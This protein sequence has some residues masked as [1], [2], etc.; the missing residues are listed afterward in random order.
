MKTTR[1]FNH[2]VEVIVKA[3]QNASTVAN[4][5]LRHVDH[6]DY[7]RQAHDTIDECGYCGA[8]WDPADPDDECNDCCDEERAE[9]DEDTPAT[10]SQPE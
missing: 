6:V 8:R 3:G 1:M 9:Y 5:I 10:D 7:V 2:R 4:Q